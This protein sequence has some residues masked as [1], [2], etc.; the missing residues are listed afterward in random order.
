MNPLDRRTFFKAGA[1]GSGGLLLGGAAGALT[2]ANAAVEVGRTLARDL[3]IPWGVAFYKSG[4]ALVSERGSADIYR[5]SRRGGKRRVGRVD[6]VRDNAGEGGLL[7]LAIAPNFCDNRRV[8]AYISTASD[9]RVVRMTNV[10][11]RLLDQKLVLGGIPT[12][13]IHNGGRLAFG[14]DGLLYVSTG[15]A[16]DSSSSQSTS[17][18]G[19]K[20]LRMTP[21]GEAP[22]GNPFNN[23]VWSFGHRNVQ[24]LAFH[25]GDLWA[26][27]LGQSTRDELN[28]IVK[29]HN[30]GWPDVE[31]GD[32]R[33]GF[34][35][36][37]VTWS[38][39]STCSPSGL[40]IA[41]G[42]AFVGALAGQALM[43]V[44]LAGPDKGKKRRLFHETFGR[45]RTVQKAPDGSL[46]ITTSNRDRDGAG[47]DDDRVIRISV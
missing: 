11:G 33:G 26:T 1:V 47:P 28:R 3:V 40:A 36:P 37:F 25:R 18:L 46:W 13:D 12:D 19:G 14:P 15:D 2:P 35:D 31:G 27:E 29:G 4:D 24:G 17:S 7:G 39:T 32:G 6:N 41:H 10:A 21:G 16:G 23:L 8:Y 38:P 45:I 44:D 30:Y 43:R 20:I 22:A 9:N 34:H 42:K 5:V